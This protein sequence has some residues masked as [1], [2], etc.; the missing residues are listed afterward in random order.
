MLGEK[1][2]RLLPKPRWLKCKICDGVIYR[3]VR[4][5]L[6]SGGVRTVCWESCCPNTGECFSRGTAAVLILGSRCTRSCRFCGI[7]GGPTEPPDP[8]EPAR[9]AEAVRQLGLR[10]VVITSVTRDDLPDG[11]AEQFAVTVKELRVRVKDIRVEVLIPDFA[12]SEKAL[13]TVVSARPDVIAHNL[14]TVQRLFPRIRPEADYGRS[15]ALLA[16]ARTLD[17]GILTKSGLM[18]GMGESPAEVEEALRDLIS[19]GC[20]VVTI[21]QYIA[22]SRGHA[23]VERFV[24]PDEFTAWRETALEMGF[25]TVSSGPLVRSSYRAGE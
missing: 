9:V 4:D 23:P 3:R 18:L 22:P 15:L 7:G 1:P 10:Y 2:G 16:S 21:G 8:D 6:D 12:G 17:P 19:A 24:P 13:R 20:R 14:D 11:G 25:T 5:I